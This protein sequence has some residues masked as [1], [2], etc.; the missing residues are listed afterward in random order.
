MPQEFTNG[1]LKFTAAIDQEG[2]TGVQKFS[3]EID[4]SQVESNGGNKLVSGTQYNVPIT[5]KK[6]QLT[7]GTPTITPWNKKDLGNIDAEM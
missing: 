2:E 4:L 7:V 6:T 5:V 3:A 1:N